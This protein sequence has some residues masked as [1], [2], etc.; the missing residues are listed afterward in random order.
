MFVPLAIGYEWGLQA[1]TAFCV[2]L[3]V[4]NRYSFGRGASGIVSDPA[5]QHNDR[6]QALKITVASLLLAIGTTGLVVFAV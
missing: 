1:Y 5:A 6:L 2:R 3:A 4:A